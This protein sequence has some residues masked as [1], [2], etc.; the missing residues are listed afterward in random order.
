MIAKTEA[1]WLNRN[2][3]EDKVKRSSINNAINDNGIFSLSGIDTQLSSFDDKG[4]ILLRSKPASKELEE[5]AVRKVN[6]C[7]KF[8]LCSEEIEKVK[9]KN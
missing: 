3:F 9:Y 5:F 7:W 2:D 1:I 8:S 6:G 4:I